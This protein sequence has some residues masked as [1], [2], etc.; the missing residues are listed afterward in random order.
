VTLE[1]RRRDAWLENEHD[2]LEDKIYRSYGVLRYTKKITTKDAMMLLAQ[3][4]L[5][6]DLD[7]ISLTG[8]GSDIHRLMVEIQPAMLQKNMHRTMEAPERDKVRA[9]YINDRLPS[10][11][12]QI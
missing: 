7:I 4:K 5:G 11:L 6:S 2:E 1:R 10:M 3:L 12:Q 8:N 9:K